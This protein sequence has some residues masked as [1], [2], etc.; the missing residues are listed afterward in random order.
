MR[1]F[2]K[3]IMKLHK[4]CNEKS[5]NKTARMYG[6]IQQILFILVCRMLPSYAPFKCT[7]FF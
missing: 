7:D 1:R 4:Q 6:T 3:E 5:A 2:D